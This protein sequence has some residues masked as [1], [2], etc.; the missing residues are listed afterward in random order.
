MGDK[1]QVYDE[2]KVE[3]TAPWLEAPATLI[4]PHNGRSFEVQVQFC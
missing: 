1:L 2:L 4:L 3:C